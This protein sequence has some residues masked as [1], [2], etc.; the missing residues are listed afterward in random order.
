[1][2]E[3]DL[4]YLGG[5]PG[6]LRNL[7]G[8]WAEEIDALTPSQTNTVVFDTPFGDLAGAYHCRLLCDRIHPEGAEVLA[9][10]GEDFY[11]GEPAVTVNQFGRGEAY[12]LATALD[13]DALVRLPRQALRRQ[14]HRA[15]ARWRPGGPGSPPR[16]SPSGETLLYALNH[17]P[18][19]VSVPL[20]DAAHTD[21]LTGR[22][23][24]GEV[25]LEAHGVLILA[26]PTVQGGHHDTH[27]DTRKLKPASRPLPRGAMKPPK[28]S[29]T[30]SWKHSG[31]T[32]LTKIVNRKPT[33]KPHPR[34]GRPICANCSLRRQSRLNWLSRN[35][36]IL[37][38]EP[39]IVKTK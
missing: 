4:V 16:V 15:A 27:I 7:L 37:Q 38:H 9:T 13:G 21:L 24:S 8:I 30:P 5:Y 28:P 17:N 18:Y 12:Y 23:L 34:N 32:K 39:I 26:P 10:Y 14:G 22:A 6:P 25:N 11:A 31:L 1:M 2:D 20:P 3:N 19:P 33:Q 36:T 35:L 29:L